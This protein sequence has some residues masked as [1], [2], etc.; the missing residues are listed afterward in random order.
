MRMVLSLWLCLTDSLMSPADTFGL[1]IRIFDV[2]K[3]VCC[4]LR[5]K[6]WWAGFRAVMVSMPVMDFEV[7]AWY[8]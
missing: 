2:K 6:A 4:G 7:Y 8:W 1:L 5:W 3:S